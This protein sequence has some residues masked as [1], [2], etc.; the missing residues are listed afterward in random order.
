MTPQAL[1][2]L[3]RQG[4]NSGIEF[5]RDD[6]RPE[7]L[8]REVVAFANFQ[9][10]QVLLGIEDDGT[11]S[12]LQR[13]DLEH[14]V[15]DTVFGRFVHPQLLPYYEEVVQLFVSS[16]SAQLVDHL[17]RDRTWNYPPDALREALLN[18]IVHRDWT[19]PG[20]VEVVLYRDR[21]TVTSPG[22]L[23]NSMTL[24]KMFAGQRSARNPIIVKVMRDYGYAEHRGMGV[25]RKI[26]PLTREYAG[27]DA[28]FEATDDFVRVTLPARSGSVVVK[29]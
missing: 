25:R 16:E 3:V 20:D 17:R 28:S 15:M 14:W 27:K 26:V 24:E 19:R 6:L 11:P 12:G 10:G 18:A 5:K 23:Q 29:P 1:M 22:A 4:E 2:Q 7:Q 13:A 21:L 8:A 9:G